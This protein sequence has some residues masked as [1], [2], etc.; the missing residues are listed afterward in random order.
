MS[1]RARRL[2]AL[3]EQLPEALDSLARALRA[4]HPL[5]AGIEMLGIEFPAPLGPEMRRVWEERRL[6]M[7]WDQALEGLSRRVPILSM[8]VFVAAVELQSRAGGRLTDVLARL[9]ESMREASALKGEVHS[10]AAH[11]K[12]TGNVLTVLP[13]FIAAVMS[14]VSPGYLNILMSHPIGKDLIA[15]ALVALVAAHFLIR[16]IVDVKL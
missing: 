10:L 6:G 5:A 1:R 8:S 7:P 16:H 4:G 12:I 2:A 14:V 3:E 13:A 15:A 9:S 11:G